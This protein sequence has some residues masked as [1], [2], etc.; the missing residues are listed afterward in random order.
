MS[1]A[2]TIINLLGLQPH[3]EGGYFKEVYRSADIIEAKDLPDRY[4]GDRNF[5]TSIYFLLAEND[6]SHFHKIQSDEIWHFYS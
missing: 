6:K 5:S 2:R 1:E 3:P 4:K